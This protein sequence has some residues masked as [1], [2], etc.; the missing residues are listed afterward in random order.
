MLRVRG[1][2]VKV[3]RFPV[4]GVGVL[5]GPVLVVNVTFSLLTS[6]SFLFLATALGYSSFVILTLSL[7]R[8]RSGIV[9]WYKRPAIRQ[10]SETALI[11]TSDQ[12]CL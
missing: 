6:L 3:W 5:P 9:P 11:V 8:P 10:V 2:H 4:L 1:L 7:F 12:C